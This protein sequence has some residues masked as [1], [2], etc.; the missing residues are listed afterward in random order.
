MESKYRY[1]TLSEI[2]CASHSKHLSKS[3]TRCRDPT[4]FQTFSSAIVCTNCSSGHL[5]P[6]YQSPE[7]LDC[8]WLCNQCNFSLN[9]DQVQEEVL[10]PLSLA[11]IELTNNLCHDEEVEESDDENSE[12]ESADS[13]EEEEEEDNGTQT[14]N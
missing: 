11:K 6:T 13:E 14:Q 1:L 10:E 2:N 5:L 3:T 12:D 9:N 8:T 7:S 4:E